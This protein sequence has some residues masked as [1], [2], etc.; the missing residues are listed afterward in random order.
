M[1]GLNAEDNITATGATQATAYQLTQSINRITTGILNTG[2]RLPAF[3]AD[4][5]NFCVVRNSTVTNKL[6]YPNTGEEIN[7]LGPN[8]PITLGA[9]GY[10]IYRVSDTRWITV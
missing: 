10:V 3:S 6:I 1:L 8:N 4:I 5:T 2:V 7:G 9:G